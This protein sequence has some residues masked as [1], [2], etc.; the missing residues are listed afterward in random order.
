MLKEELSDLKY[1]ISDIRGCR[2]II[3]PLTAGIK[4]DSSI[5][6]EERTIFEG[7]IMVSHSDLLKV[8][9][10]LKG[11]EEAFQHLNDKNEEKINFLKQKRLEKE[12][13]KLGATVVWDSINE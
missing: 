2:D 9:S 11:V 5:E 3:N 1:G 7:F 10:L 4:I 8:G 13:Q 12:A 6:K